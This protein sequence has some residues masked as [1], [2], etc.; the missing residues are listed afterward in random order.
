MNFNE[1]LKAKICSDG[2]DVATEWNKALEKNL[3]Q[4]ELNKN[5]MKEE[6]TKVLAKY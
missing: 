3:R 4:L 6:R 5:K 1:K 2:K